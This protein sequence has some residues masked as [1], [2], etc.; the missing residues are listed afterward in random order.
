MIDFKNIS[1]S[2]K[3]NKGQD[4]HV[5]NSL[6]F[7]V[8]KKEIFGIVGP[9]GCGKTTI[10]KLASDLAPNPQSGSIFINGVRPEIARKKK[11]VAILTQKP[12]LL[13]WRNVY[14]NILLPVQIAGA[15]NKKNLKRIDSLLDIAGMLEYKKYQ[16]HELSG[17]MQ[18]RVSLVRCLMTK[19][20]ILLLDEP[21]S[22]LD[23]IL[24]EELLE[25]LQVF[26]LELSLTIIHVSH[27][28]E[29]SILFCDKV[30]VLGQRPTSVSNI[31]SVSLGRPRKFSNRLEK[32]FLHSL[33][34]LRSALKVGVK[35]H[36]LK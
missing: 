2:Y 27:S 7:S 16:I 34:E 18:Q 9:S 35:K 28:L 13:P 32:V 4:T 3:N 14:D 6:T 31:V 5:L 24:K 15:I 11:Q 21:F 12:V 10:L 20:V 33:T 25:L 29:D 22:A 26:S 17:G 19:P 8:G 23:E 1:F 36:S 30:A